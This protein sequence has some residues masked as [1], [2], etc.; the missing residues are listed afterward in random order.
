MHYSN[1]ACVMKLYISEMFLR[2]TP[3]RARA[4]AH[5]VYTPVGSGRYNLRGLY[6]SFSGVHDGN[7]PLKNASE[8]SSVTK[9][10][11]VSSARFTALQRITVEKNSRR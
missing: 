11:V 7:L 9:P 4:R 10:R 3:A 6:P 5:A 1:L 2:E 8:I